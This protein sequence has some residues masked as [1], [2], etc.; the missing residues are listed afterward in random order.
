VKR[1]D[2]L[3]GVGALALTPS[4]AS[5]SCADDAVRTT[6]MLPDRSPGAVGFLPE[7]FALAERAVADAVEKRGV[8]GAVLL[9]GR[10]GAVVWRKAYGYAGLR[11]ERRP[12]QVD[13]LFDMASVTKPVAAATATMQLVES[14]RVDLEATVG[15]YLPPFA[16]AGGDKA[17]ITVRHL[18]THAGGLVAGGAF[19]GKH[20]TLPEMVAVIAQSRQVS[21]PGT[22]FLYS[23][24]SAV[25]LGAIVEAVSGQTLDA[26][27]REHIWQ[28][29]GMT[30]TDFRPTGERA[31]RSAATTNGE[32]TPERRGRVHDPLSASIGGV[33]GNAGLFSTVD[34]LARFCQMLLNGGEYAGAR[35]LKPETVR[36]M[37]TRQSPFEGND[38][39]LGWDLASA[40][41]V[42][43]DLPPG[44]FGHTG[45]TGTSVWIDPMTQTF[46][47]VLTNAVHA[48]PAVQEAARGHVVRMRRMVSSVVASAIP[49]L[50]LPDPTEKLAA[51]LAA[52]TARPVAVAGRRATG[53][54]RT[55]L[56]ALI[57]AGF[58]TLAGRKVG[59]V[60][61]HTAVDKQGKHLADLLHGSGKVNIV[62]LFGPEHSIRG[63]VDASADNSRD[64][65]TGLPVVSLYNL[66]LPPAE[67]YRPTA[68][69]L[70]GIDTLVFDI[71]DIGARY[72]TY[73]ATMGYCMEAAVKH[74][75]RF[76][77]LDRPNPLGGNLVEGPLLDPTMQGRFTAYHTAPITHGMTVGELAR[78]FNEERKIGVTLEV[79]KM[80]G[81]TR[82]MRWEETGLPWVNPSPNIRNPLQ[83]E[84]YPG[85]GL[86][87]VLPLSVGRGTDTPFEVFGSPYLDGHILAA[88]LNARRLPGVSFA[89]T[90]FIPT[91]R[92]YK[93]Q[94]C[95]GVRI[96]VT[97]RAALM[98]SALG[99]HL[100]DAL[101]RRYPD[102]FTA[103]VLDRMKGMVG[104]V[105]I[106]QEIAKGTPPAQIISG[107]A[108]DVAEWKRRRVPFM[109]YG[110]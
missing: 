32:D 61:N 79:I 8:P 78:M 24:Y 109:L 45:F 28:P 90:A 69:Q 100:A 72:Y 20:L 75:L 43:G 97:D 46:I 104:N 31:L 38:R 76:V 64:A 50:A 14:G 33:S 35:I 101:V 65:R 5:V 77:V 95:G 106:P 30:D 86:L 102:R 29:L 25:L 57:A 66:K 96:T 34:D 62:T 68:E 82:G 40:Y 36:L 59:I 92:E 94:P 89:P 47:I 12:M 13:T 107:W 103:Q 19:A 41:T 49:E 26:W 48:D 37:T 91:T 2:F 98:P 58:G 18:L 80:M 27:C 87:E 39:G 67:R 15:K 55:G 52:P 63:D 99:I 73:I 7:R 93:G 9:I 84:L 54:V 108:N 74:N 6:P 10:K 42:R 105:A 70:K 4:F 1:R 51:F 21:P 22:R 71:Q 85:V 110:D 23:D 83:A 44:S 11:P 56:E 60:C 81:W 16:A 88:D 53:M 17:A 3:G